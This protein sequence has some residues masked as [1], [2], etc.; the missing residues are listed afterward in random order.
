MIL[1]Y[2]PTRRDRFILSSRL[3]ELFG[4][5]PSQARYLALNAYGYC[6]DLLRQLDDLHKSADTIRIVLENYGLK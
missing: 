5:S 3:M 2:E 6:S 1:T 4:F